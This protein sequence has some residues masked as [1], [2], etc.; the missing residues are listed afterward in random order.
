MSL[1]YVNPAVRQMDLLEVI[2]K[3]RGLTKTEM[4]RELRIGKSYYS[5]MINGRCAISKNM[6]LRIRDKFGV[7]LDA[8]LPR[9]VHTVRTKDV[10]TDSGTAKSR[11]EE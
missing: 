2:R 8:I 10:C 5:M 4:A 6:A 7:S 11:A 1:E 9:E 3:E